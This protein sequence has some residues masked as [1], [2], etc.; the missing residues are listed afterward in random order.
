[1]SLRGQVQSAVSQF[2]LAIAIVA[3]LALSA[4]AQTLTVLHNFAGPDGNGA[5]SGPT[6]DR[7]GN[8]YGTTEYGGNGHGNVYKLAHA[9][10][11]WVL[12]N[13]Y[14]F[15]GDEHHDGEYPL[16]TVVFGPDGTLYGTTSQGG[17][18]P[19]LVLCSTSVPQPASATRFNVPG[20]RLCSTSSL[21]K[22]MARIP[23]RP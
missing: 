11:G 12:T 5:Q 19:T 7:A 2:I 22:P 17:A 1:M 9:G 20:R 13:L 10:S 16:A 23:K 6:I 14:E 8:L 21:A 18:L 15:Q 3:I 4:P